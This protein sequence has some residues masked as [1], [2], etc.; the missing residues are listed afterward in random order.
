MNA[1]PLFR[2]AGRRVL[3]ALFR[4]YRVALSPLIGPVCRYEPSCSHYAEEAIGRFGLLRG[5]AL[6]AWRLLRCHPF[7]RG[8]LDPVPARPHLNETEGARAR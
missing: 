6:A 1:R 4:V 3:A 8:G 7:S 5:G 2:A